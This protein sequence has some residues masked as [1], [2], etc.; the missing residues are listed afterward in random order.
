M[1]RGSRFCR[2]LAHCYVLLVVV[3]VVV[4]VVAV[5]AAAVVVCNPFWESLAYAIFEK[6]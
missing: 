1:S 4:V 3:V 5:V 6:I 2:L